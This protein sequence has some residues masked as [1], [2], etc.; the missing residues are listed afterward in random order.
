MVGPDEAGFQIF[1]QALEKNALPVCHAL[2]SFLFGVPKK[3][4]RFAQVQLLE[5]PQCG[6]AETRS[7]SGIILLLRCEALYSNLVA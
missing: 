3:H 2:W 7:L 4:F 6:D 5:N 1:F